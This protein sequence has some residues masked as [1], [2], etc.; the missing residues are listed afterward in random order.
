MKVPGHMANKQQQGKLEPVLHDS[1][2]RFFPWPLLTSIWDGCNILSDLTSANQ[3]DPMEEGMATHSMPGESHGQRSP[4]GYSLWGHKE[5]NMTD[6]L[7][8]A[9]CPSIPGHRNTQEY[10]FQ[11]KQYWGHLH[12]CKALAGSNWRELSGVLLVP[13]L[14]SVGN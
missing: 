3:E 2:P 1:S 6:G 4:A 12:S 13:F 8:H 5:L 11:G 14:R 9:S 7:T 10:C